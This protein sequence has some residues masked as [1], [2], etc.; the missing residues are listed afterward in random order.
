MDA[1]KGVQRRRL[2]R[3]AGLWNW[4]ALRYFEQLCPPDAKGVR[5]PM[6]AGHYV[7]EGRFAHNRY[8][9]LSGQLG[10]RWRFMAT[11][12]RSF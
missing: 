6:A 3:D 9:D 2:S 4:L 1:F 5:K 11:T 12:A 8:Y 7:L 10:T